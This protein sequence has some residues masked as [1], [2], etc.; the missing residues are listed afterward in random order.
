MD[1]GAPA[2]APLSFS[3]HFAAGRGSAR[4]G[5][6]V[7]AAGGQFSVHIPGRGGPKPE[8]M[9]M[10]VRALYRGVPD[11][12]A[13]PRAL[14]WRQTVDR[15]RPGFAAEVN[16]TLTPEALEM[17]RLEAVAEAKPRAEAIEQPLAVA[18]TAC[19]ATDAPAGGLAP[20]AASS[21]S[22]APGS[23]AATRG[24]F[25]AF[26]HALL[27]TS[28][29]YILCLSGGRSAARARGAP[30]RAGPRTPAGACLSRPRESAP[31]TGGDDSEDTD[32]LTSPSAEL[33]EDDERDGQR[34]EDG[35]RDGGG[36]AGV[37]GVPYWLRSAEN[38]INHAVNPDDAGADGAARGAQPRQY[39]RRQQQAKSGDDIARIGEVAME[40]M[41]VL[42]DELWIPDP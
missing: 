13:P 9:T 2:R 42:L 17:A 24:A 40:E 22:S 8:P 31:S 12:P 7:G 10:S 11:G 34:V 36:A 30:A 27:A 37:R 35:D 15:P 20:E 32:G 33:T 23:G 29:V 26:Q 25:G 18:P 6:E 19:N 28:M 4:L 39:A 21:S 1:A 5:D 41:A 38:N 3:V 14:V 16:V